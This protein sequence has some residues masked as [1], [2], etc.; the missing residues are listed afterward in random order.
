MRSI[1]KSLLL[2]VFI[3]TCVTA[4]IALTWAEEY[5]QYPPRQTVSPEAIIADTLVARPAGIV[6]TVAGT[7]VFIVALPFSLI[8]GDTADVAEKLV[9]KPGR[10]TFT[11]RLGEDVFFDLDSDCQRQPMV[12]C[13]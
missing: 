2:V 9:A 10:Y 11:R 5:Q 13:F 4:G 12:D 6:A 3:C 8:T 7:A 1:L